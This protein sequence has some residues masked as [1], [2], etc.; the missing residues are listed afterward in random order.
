M[1]RFQKDNPL[2]LYPSPGGSGR[3]RKEKS[4]DSMPGQAITNYS[5]AGKS[6]RRRIIEIFPVPLIITGM[7]QHGLQGAGN[8]NSDEPNSG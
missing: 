1:S 3:R 4:M 7:L 8:R 6:G 2:T 5:G